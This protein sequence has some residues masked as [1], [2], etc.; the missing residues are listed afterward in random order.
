MVSLLQCLFCLVVEKN[1]R[2]QPWEAG[3]LQLSYT[4]L[5]S[6]VLNKDSVPIQK[7]KGSQDSNSVMLG[8]TYHCVDFEVTWTLNFGQMHSNARH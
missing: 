8:I 6:E 7:G 2:L 5:Q 4:L 3:T 1:L